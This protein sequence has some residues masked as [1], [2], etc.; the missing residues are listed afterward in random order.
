MVINE[1]SNLE[2]ETELPEQKPSEPEPET[3]AEP[4]PPDYEWV[5]AIFLPE[6]FE[7]VERLEQETDSGV[8]SPKLL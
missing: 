1:Q 8:V 5:V 6:F 7:L 2:S 4:T 3:E